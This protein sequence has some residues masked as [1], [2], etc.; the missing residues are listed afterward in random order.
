MS[1]REEVEKLVDY[2]CEQVL[3]WRRIR[4][5][6]CECTNLEG[7]SDICNFH[8]KE[9]YWRT[10]LDEGEDLLLM[11]MK[12]AEFQINAPIFISKFKLPNEILV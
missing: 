5:N 11:D 3:Q 7:N 12:S 10:I 6:D 9:N 4:D 2:A 8:K 1:L